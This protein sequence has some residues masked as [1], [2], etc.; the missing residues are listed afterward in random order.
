MASYKSSQWGSR[1]EAPQI[2]VITIILCLLGRSSSVTEMSRRT[3]LNVPLK[4]RK[5]LSRPQ[6]LLSHH[7]N[8]RYSSVTRPKLWFVMHNHEFNRRS[9]PLASLAVKQISSTFK[10]GRSILLQ[11]KRS[12]NGR[13]SQAFLLFY[14]SWVKRKSKQGVCKQRPANCRK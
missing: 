1:S 13:L 9:P 2:F 12:I 14:N 7:R 8:N 6:N 3:E 11:R 4:G 10:T 5:T